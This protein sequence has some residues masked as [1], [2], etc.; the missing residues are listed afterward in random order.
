MQAALPDLARL[1]ITVFRKWPYLYDGAL[2]YE[3]RYLARFASTERSVIVAA[4]DGETVI[5][6]ATASPIGGHVPEFSEPLVKA[7]LPVEEIFYFGESVLLP[8]YRGQGIGHAFFDHREAHARTF[9]EYLFAAFCA[10]VRPADHPLRDPDYRPLDPFWN[11]RGY[12]PLRG[13]ASSF[14]WKDIGQ[15]AETPKDM[16]FWMR[17]L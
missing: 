14:A 5:G 9:P 7:G 6:A 3:E 12:F 10:V 11:K 13:V 4:Y 1:R 2:A 17:A 15:E 8:G 16:R